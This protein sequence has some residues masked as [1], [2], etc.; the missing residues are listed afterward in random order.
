MVYTTFE[1]Y[2]GAKALTDRVITHI[3][4]VPDL[5]LLEL[6]KVRTFCDPSHLDPKKQTLHQK[7]SSNDQLNGLYRFKYYTFLH[8]AGE[9]IAEMAD[10]CKGLLHSLNNRV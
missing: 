3:P 10:L 1:I 9:L 8:E 5:S 4:D 7:L 2:L 6:F